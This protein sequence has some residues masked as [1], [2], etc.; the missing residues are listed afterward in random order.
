MI[1]KN[2]VNEFFV[3]GI[4]SKEYNADLVDNSSSK[5]DVG[6][7][8]V[9]YEYV[10][11]SNTGSFT[12]AEIKAGLKKIK[13]PVAFVEEDYVSAAKG[14]TK[15]EEVLCSGICEI[16]IPDRRMF[17][18]SC[19]TNISSSNHLME[20]VITCEYTFEAVQ[21]SELVSA[22]VDSDRLYNVGSGKSSLCRI[23]AKV[24]SSGTNYKIAGVTF[25]SVQAE[26]LIVIDGFSQ[27]VT[28]N[29]ASCILDTDLTSF[30]LIK[31]GLNIFDTN[32]GFSVE[33]YPTYV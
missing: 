5:F 14:K 17:Y 11:S 19:L 25:A 3:N 20:G 9:K 33:Y 2:I 23:K 4:S 28:K 10:Y 32:Q 29:G 30:P 12:S 22:V 7:T 16:Y 15:L 31:P 24:A 6:D 8:D 13:I 26:D 27:M 18:K 1:N 21:H